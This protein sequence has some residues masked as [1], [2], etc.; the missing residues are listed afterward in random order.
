MRERCFFAG[1]GENVDYLNSLIRDKTKFKFFGNL[2]STQ[3]KNW[4]KSLDVYVQA[5]NGE[6]HSTSILQA[7]GMNLPILA[8]NVSGIKNFLIPKKN[9]GLTFENN[10]SSLIKYIKI[11]LK[12][13]SNKRSKIIYSQKKYISNN[14]SEDIFLYEYLKIIKKFFK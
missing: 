9:I 4:Y 3:L 13:S 7:M 10:T 12:M 5:T 14:Y 8:S 1:N 6:G 2:K 11:F